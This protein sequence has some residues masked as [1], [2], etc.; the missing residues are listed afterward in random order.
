[1]SVLRH[2]VLL[3]I[4]AFFAAH[5]KEAEG[6]AVLPNVNGTGVGAEVRAAPWRSQQYLNRTLHQQPKRAPR[7]LDHLST[8]WSARAWRLAL[9]SRVCVLTCTVPFVAAMH[10]MCN[11][12]RCSP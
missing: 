6:F 9:L 11:D 7:V 4:A 2:L 10:A 1:M 12:H 3:A 8:L 5:V